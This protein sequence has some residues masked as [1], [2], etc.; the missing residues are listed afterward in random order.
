MSLQD[1]TLSY[2][3]KGQGVSC[4]TTDWIRVIMVRIVSAQ[5]QISRHTR[6]ENRNRQRYKRFFLQPLDN[7]TRPEWWLVLQCS[8]AMSWVCKVHALNTARR[9]WRRRKKRIPYQKCLDLLPLTR[10][11][12]RVH[13]IAGVCRGERGQPTRRI[14][15][16]RRGEIPRVQNCRRKQW[17][18]HHLG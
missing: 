16:G 8:R 13:P 15:P 14:A 6:V 9:K 4:I 12:E 2:A 3:N 10:A 17:R 18:D 11:N 7:H 5:S 1:T